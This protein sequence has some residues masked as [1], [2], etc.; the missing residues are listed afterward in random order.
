MLFRLWVFAAFSVP[1]L[2]FGSG[3]AAQVP[4][5]VPGEICFTPT[6]WCWANP[7]GPPGYPCVC[8]DPAS[9]SLVEGTL[10]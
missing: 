9:G 2:L 5:H 6:L 8:I 4:P 7:P 1:L 10:N 3:A